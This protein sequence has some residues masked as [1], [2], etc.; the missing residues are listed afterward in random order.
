MRLIEQGIDGVLPMVA[1]GMREIAQARRHRGRTQIG[2]R[3][4]QAVREP[5]DGLQILGRV[6]IAQGAELLGGIVEKNGDGFAQQILVTRCSS[7]RF[8]EHER[9]ARGAAHPLAT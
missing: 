3:T 9:R 8:V 6:S 2:H 4:L 7:Q 5:L 1:G